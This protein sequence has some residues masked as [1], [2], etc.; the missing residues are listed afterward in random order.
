MQEE[1]LDNAN[2]SPEGEKES[3]DQSVESATPEAEKAATEKVEAIEVNPTEASEVQVKDQ[4]IVEAATDDTDQK[5]EKDS[6]DS[7]PEST[8]EAPE[9]HHEEEHFEDEVELVEQIDVAS[10]GKA[11]LIIFVDGLIENP[12]LNIIKSHLNEAKDK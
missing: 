5:A 9:G 11:E 10:M 4:N 1:N 7:E 6:V 2:P 3:V 12:K 8:E